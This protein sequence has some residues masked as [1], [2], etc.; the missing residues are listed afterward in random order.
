ME[1]QG[2]VFVQLPQDN[3]GGSFK[4]P[5]RG[6]AAR[7]IHA[8]INPTKPPKGDRERKTVTLW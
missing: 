8:K 1:G 3:F 5:S 2:S 6:S 7:R 4:D